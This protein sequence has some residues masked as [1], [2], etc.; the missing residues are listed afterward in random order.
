MFEIIT[1]VFVINFIS[2][3]EQQ[4]FGDILFE[5]KKRNIEEYDTENNS[6]LT[7]EGLVN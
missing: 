1:L 6:T 4:L 2:L 3:T 7:N 5:S